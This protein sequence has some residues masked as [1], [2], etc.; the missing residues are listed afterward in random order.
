MR[1]YVCVLTVTLGCMAASGE[2]AYPLWDPD[3]PLPRVAEVS[4]PAAIT[5]VR[6][7]EAVA[8][9][10]T[11]LHGPGIFAF[12]GQLFASWANSPVDENSAGERCRGRRSVDGGYRWGSVEVIAPGFPGEERHSHGAFFEWEGRLYS[13]VARFGSTA[14]VPG[15]PPFPGL[16]SELFVWQPESKDWVSRGIWIDDIWPLETPKP[17]PDGRWIQGGVD[18]ASQP[19]VAISETDDPLGAWR[20]VKLPVPETRPLIFAETTVMVL[21]DRLVAV[22]RPSEPKTALV[23][24]STDGGATWS[25]VSPSNLPAVPSKPLAGRLSTGQH[26][27]IYNWIDG[28]ETQL[29]GARLRDSLL[30]AVTRPGGDRFVRQY[31]VRHGQAPAMR[32]PG[33]AKGGSWAYP[34]ACEHDGKLYIVYS[35]N[36]EDCELAIIPVE[37]LAAPE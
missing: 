31:R 12:E 10:D 3:V 24:V 33:R 17:L 30:V 23:S 13:P 26:F 22:I 28:A 11:F 8:G 5:Y 35:E 27:L 32:F 18:F 9:D 16:K 37:C 25:P 2:E 34:N 15:G 29:D 21:P 36:K 7:H 6:V 14:P 4:Y 20:T 1:K 19:V